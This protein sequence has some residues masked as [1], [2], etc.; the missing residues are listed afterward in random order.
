[1]FQIMSIIAFVLFGLSGCSKNIPT[2][3]QRKHIAYTISEQQNL[4]P[5]ILHTSNFNLF[6]YSKV[7]KEC[8]SLKVYIEGDG[9]SWVTR[10]IV[11]DDPTPINPIALKL[12]NIDESQ[13]KIYLARPCQYVT[14]EQ[15]HEKYWTTKRFSDEIIQSF[16]EA[17]DAL[18]LQYHNK[19]FELVGYSGGGAVA[20]LVGARRDDIKRI[21]T[22]AGNLD[23]KRW[24]E[25]HSLSPLEGSL[26]PADFWIKL[27]NIE[28]IH[29]IGEEDKVIPK[30][31]FDSYI[32]K[33]EDKTKIHSLQ[34][35]ATH[36]VGWEEKY[37]EFLKF[38]SF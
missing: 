6:S 26:N 2:L 36:N 14:T 32:S 4:T 31:I 16:Y 3:E 18:K 11:S 5:K 35:E 21:M 25:Y 8:N 22:I 10:S 17:L 9:F 19:E 27:Q 23:T 37:K 20:L 33:F 1:M 7:S 24:V 38:K 34:Y 29:L 13:C 15:C 12:M 30:D 28:Q